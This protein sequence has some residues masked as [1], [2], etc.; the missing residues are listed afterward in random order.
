M[1]IRKYTYI[2]V[3]FNKDEQK[4][5]DKIFKRLTKLGYERE[6]ED[7]GSY[8]DFCDQYIRFQK[9]LKK[10]FPTH[11]RSGKAQTKNKP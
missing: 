10:E 11:L 9:P 6:N 7:A 5:A 8:H 3:Y 4:A 2:D 1:E